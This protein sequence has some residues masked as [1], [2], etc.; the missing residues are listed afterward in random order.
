MRPSSPRRDLTRFHEA[1][2]GRGELADVL[3]DAFQIMRTDG[4]RYDNETYL[5][6]RRPTQRTRSTTSSDA[7]PATC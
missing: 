7:K 1:L 5:S 3:G 4:T 6:A 2:A